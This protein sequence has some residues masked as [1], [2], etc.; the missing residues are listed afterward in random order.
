[1]MTVSI[2]EQSCVSCGRCI[3]VCP[4]R[5]IMPSGDSEKSPE[6]VNPR[7]C[8]VCGHCVAICPSD[9]ILHSDF[10]ED[11]IH[12]IDTDKLP[13]AQ[14][15]MLLCKARRSSRLFSSKP[16]PDSLLSMVIEAAGRA[17][18]ASNSQFV[19]FTVVTNPEILRYISQFTID[20]LQKKIKPIDN[21][22]LR[23]IFRAINPQGAKYIPL[24][25]EMKRLFDQG[26]D[27]VLRGAT[28]VIF[29]HTSRHAKFGSTD[30]D[31]AYQNASL[32]AQSL[33]LAHFYT[34]F[35]CTALRMGASD[36]FCQKLG[37]R[38]DIHAGMAVAMSST[39][40]KKYIDKKPLKVHYIK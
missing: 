9:S 5:V 39:E 35:V 10:P 6:V 29:I 11:K 4:S 21:F 30:S 12:R 3:E 15:L 22:I 32:M 13:T 37:I 19:E 14:Q 20:T 1:M 25:R 7:G 23:P 27:M 18:T 36:K 8:I 16:I 38:G 2:A 28:A 40:F 26:N 24:F 34:G 17:P 33:G 31:L